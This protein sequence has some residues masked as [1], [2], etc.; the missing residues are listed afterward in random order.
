MKTKYIFVT[1]GVTSSLGKG[2]VASSLGHILINSGFSCTIVKMDPYLNVD[3][4]TMSPYEHGE[5]FVTKDGAETDLDLGHYERFLNR[6]LGKDNSVTMGKIYN[7]VLKAER[8]GDYLGKTVQVIPH[9]TDEL[10]KSYTKFDDQVDVVIVEIGGCVGDI[11]STPFIEAVRQTMSEKK[12]DC[13]SIHVTLLPR[14]STTGEL[15][16][17]PS[18]HSVRNLRELGIQPDI[19]VT[20]SND[21]MSEDIRQKLAL[22]CSIPEHRVI[23]S[24]DSDTIY[25]M[26]YN[27]AQQGLN[28]EV[29]DILG[30]DIRDYSSDLVEYTNKLRKLDEIQDRKKIA[31]VGKYVELSDSYF[32]I[33]ESIVH[34]S[35]HLDI[36]VDISYISTDFEDSYQKDLVMDSILCKEYDAI[37]IGPGFGDRGI[38][39]KLEIASLCRQYD[40][41]CLGICLGMQMMA[42]SFARDVLGWMHADSTEFFKDTCCP[43]IDMMQ[44]QKQSKGMG[45]TMRLGSYLCDIDSDDDLCEFYG[46]NEV[47][48]RHRHRYEFNPTYVDRFE[49]KG[50]RIVGRNPGTMLTEIMRYEP[51]KFYIGVQFHPEYKSRP[52]TPHPIFVSLLSSIG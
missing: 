6:D 29:L 32:S 13:C 35:V 41:P 2:I 51:N 4:G 39:G 43:V 22:F 25:A 18:Q 24:L 46:T 3:P 26:P 5:C 8:R 14:L 12:R 47:L 50:M 9:I 10:K 34:A 37:I 42:I 21:A 27:L 23:E 36:P 16:T 40:V 30:L 11:E 44:D 45:G 19:L 31:I 28:K 17:K 20:R 38:E 1:G 49:E 33:R 15:K 7:K 52:N 48:E